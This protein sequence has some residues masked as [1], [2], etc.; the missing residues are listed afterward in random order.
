MNEKSI[1]IMDSGLGGLTC[2]RELN[3]LLPHENICY[4]GDTERSPY[5]IL[6]PNTIVKYS[7]QIASFL[8]SQSIKILIIACGTISG[9]AAEALRKTS[10]IPIID[11]IAPTA[12]MAVNTTVNKKIGVIGTATTIKKGMYESK[13]RSLMPDVELHSLACQGFVELVEAGH[14]D[15][16]DWKIKMAVEKYLCDFKYSTDIDTLLLGCT[17]FPIIAEPISKYIGRRVKLVSSGVA[18][19]HAAADYLLANGMLNDSKLAGYETFFT[20][21]SSDTFRKLGSIVLGREITGN[22]TSIRKS[23]LDQ[24]FPFK[25]VDFIAK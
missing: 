17:H 3:K 22:V 20:T 9:V 18:V 10:N 16:N 14:I 2:V 25:R 11:V 8:N 6:T 13:I 7:A 5:G 24:L 12:S 23:Y 19:A 21:G 4:F 1:G 15:Q